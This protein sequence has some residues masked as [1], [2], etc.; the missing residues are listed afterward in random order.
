MLFEAAIGPTIG[1]SIVALDHDLD[2][3]R[4]LWRY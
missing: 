2:P 1:G 3:P 4:R